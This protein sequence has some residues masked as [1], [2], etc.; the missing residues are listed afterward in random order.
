M[1]RAL[2]GAG[3]RRMR[4]LLATCVCVAAMA[5]PSASQAQQGRWTYA[6]TAGV[7]TATETDGN[8]RVT[9]T[10]TCRPPTGDI[11]ISDYSLA[12]AGRRAQT[13]AVRI[14]AMQ[15]NVPS[16]VQGSGRR[17]ALVINLPQRPPILAAV[18][19]TDRLSVTVNGQTRTYSDG[20]PARMKEVAYGCWGS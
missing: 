13:S 15:V 7:A 1:E 19:P 3:E 17:R 12:R 6:Y 2:I 16:S 18:Q 14:G 10:I 9:A 4:N 11:V 20:G 5:I 8:G